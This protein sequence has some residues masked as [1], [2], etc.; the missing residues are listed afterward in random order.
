MMDYDWALLEKLCAFHAVSGHE[1]DIVAFVRD[2]IRPWVDECWVDRLGNVVGILQGTTYPDTRL[3]LQ[4]HLDELGLIVRNITAEGFLLVERIGGMPEKSLL[5]QR[6]EIK[7]EAGRRIPGY[8]GAKSHHV[9]GADEKYRVPSVHEMFIDVGVSSRTAVE[10][11]GIRV[12]DTVTYAPNFN[13]FGDGMICAK[14]LDNRVGVFILLELLKHF[15]AR[16]PPCTLVFA[17][18]VLEEFSIRG[19]LPVVNATRPDAIISVDITVAV[20]TPAED[21]LHPVAMRQGPAVKM[22]DF[23]GRGTLGGLFSS[24]K[25]RRFIEDTAQKHAIPT[26]REVI[27]GVI[28]DPA[29]QLY[30]GDRGYVIA[31]LSI[32]QRYTHSA[33]QMCHEADITHA[34]RLLTAVATEFS[35]AL[36]LSRG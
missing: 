13:R 14:A 8:I 18:T 6:V 28:T 34:I 12:G 20:D 32:P 36:D 10:A 35:P 16:R 4:A 27:V 11:L 29:F 19:S 23:H 7:T 1:D 30:L 25:L 24:P 26:Q 5:G 2:A 21:P 15:Q 31:G 17:F 3:M 33:A 22:M 9:T